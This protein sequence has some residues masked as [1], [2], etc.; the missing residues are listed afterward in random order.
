MVGTVNAQKVT[1]FDPRGYPPRITPKPM[2]PR[3]DTLDGKT[4]YL[5]DPQFDDSGLFLEQLQ[6]CFADRMPTVKTRMVK[7][8]SV[9]HRDDPKTWEEIKANGHAAIIGVGH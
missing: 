4:I 3:L 7:L 1:V 9:Y 6:A 8:N 5:V 2:A